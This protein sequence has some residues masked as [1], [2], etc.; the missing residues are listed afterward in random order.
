[1]RLHFRARAGLRVEETARLAD[2]VEDALRREIPK[3]EIS[4]VLDNIGVPYSGL[5]LSYSTSGVIGTSDA[6]ILVALNPEHHHATADYVR[7]LRSE[8]PR[9]FPGVEFFFQPADIVSQILNF[10]LPAPVDVQVMGNDM[11]GNFV[12]AQQIAAKMRHIPRRGCACAAVDVATNVAPGHRSYEGGTGGDEHS[13]SGPER[14]DFV[15][16]K[17]SDGAEFGSIRKM[18]SRTRWRCK[19]RSIG[20]RPSRI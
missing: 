4:T 19:H 15:E 16:R 12:I 17:F 10:G 1:M 8:L 18:A 6:E 7:K 5:N 9:Q 20:L 13:R 3:E 14:S 11:Q 2:E